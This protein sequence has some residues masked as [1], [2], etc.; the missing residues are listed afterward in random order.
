MRELKLCR[1]LLLLLISKISDIRM[2]NK[3][4]S[5]ES[6]I[7]IVVAVLLII[8]LL[9]HRIIYGYEFLAS[10]F[11]SN[12][13]TYK[14]DFAKLLV[15]VVGGIFIVWGLWLNSRRTKALEQQNNNQI[16]AQ[17]DER[18]KNAIEHLGE[19]NPA[20]ILGGIHA[21]N[22][23]AEE[24]FSYRPVVLNI[25]CSYLREEISVQSEVKISKS[26]IQTIFD[27][28]FKR[29]KSNIYEGYSANLQ[30]IQYNY[31][32]LRDANFNDVDFSGANLSGTVFDG[33]SFNRSS[34][35]GADLSG[36]SMQ[37]SDLSEVYMGVALLVQA[38]L[39]KANLTKASLVKADLTKAVLN[40]CN[41]EQA[42][43]IMADLVGAQLTHVNLNEANLNKS[44]L[45]YAN[46]RSAK[47]QRTQM[48]MAN[49]E[50]AKL[51]NVLGIECVFDDSI[52][53]ETKFNKSRLRKASF[54]RANLR[55]A[56]FSGASLIDA[57][58]QG[59]NL[60]GVDMT[61]A[62]LIGANFNKA[63]LK[64]AN[65]NLANFSQSSFKDAITDGVYWGDKKISDN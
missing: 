10:Y 52:M 24:E 63:N 9:N 39:V 46:L 38:K 21:L 31:S 15:T 28:L 35:L 18:F 2:D 61:N 27:V 22:R 59:A 30:D 55:G 26:I 29:S 40:R 25:L 5:R 51:I 1:I 44:N 50:G 58:F 36:V 14:G 37:D 43:L 47:I 53:I 48:R 56:N 65:L 3:K 57:D 19:R 64:N 12:P 54:C 6:W 4:L 33:S 41:L 16:K 34:F 17:V 13:E 60:E 62:N 23:V 45:S 7:A 20:I 42:V 11:F 49:L 32:L 8:V